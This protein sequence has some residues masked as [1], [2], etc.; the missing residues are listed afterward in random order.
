MG[1]RT[2]DLPRVPV[3]DLAIQERENELVIGTHGR[4]IWVLDLNPLI[5]GFHRSRSHCTRRT[6]AVLWKRPKTSRGGKDGENADTVGETLGRP[7]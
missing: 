4:S 3:H 1:D 6:D 2:P 7:R 5:E